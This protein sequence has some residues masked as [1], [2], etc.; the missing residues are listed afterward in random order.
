[1][2]RFAMMGTRII[3][4]LA[5]LLVLSCGARVVVDHDKGEGRTVEGSGDVTTA[6]SGAGGGLTGSGGWSGSTIGSGAAGGSS[7][8]A[9]TDGPEPAESTIFANSKAVLYEVNPAAQKLVS[10]LSLSGCEAEV[11]D[12]AINSSG[13]VYATTSGGLF[14]IDTASGTCALKKSGEYPNSLAF[15]P[16]GVLDTTKEVLVGYRDSSYFRI[17]ESTGEKAL[18]GGLAEGLISG[19]DLIVTEQKRA[20]ATVKGNGCNDCLA[21]IDPANGSVLEYVGALGQADVFGLAYQKGIL[22]GFSVTGLMFQVN[23]ES[24]ATEFIPLMNGQPDLSFLGAAAPL[25]DL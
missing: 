2:S 18:I 12:I 10:A 24:A 25:P 6:N 16:K 20:Y 7:M 23:L 9:G 8:D 17:D 11:I 19:G 1:M 21:E 4:H 13:V 3:V 14:T 5:G 22:Y 15:F